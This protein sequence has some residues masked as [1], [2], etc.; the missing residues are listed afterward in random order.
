MLE[1]IHWLGHASFRINGP[2]DHAGPVVYIDPWRLPA[3]APPA[4]LILVS[5]EH[6][7]HCSPDD[8]R[9]I[10]HG[11]TLIVGNQ[12]VFDALAP[13]P[14]RVLRPWQAAMSPCGGA[15]VRAVPAYTPGHAYHDRSFGGLGFVVSVPRMDIYYAGDTALIPEMHKIGCDVAL[16][17][18]GG[19]F[20]MDYEEAV[21]AARRIRP[22]VA[23]PMHY[24]REVPGSR[25][26]G[27]HFVQMMNN[28]IRAVQLP[29]ENEHVYA[30]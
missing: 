28:G 6:H 19:S 12:R 10:T 26:N 22:L 17:P 1:R 4:D 7:D 23:V 29:V 13:L 3:G 2:P 16:L 30:G 11:K 9:Q 24:G 14:V 21:E 8:I 27:R 15:S 20:T 5:H 25:E 18:V